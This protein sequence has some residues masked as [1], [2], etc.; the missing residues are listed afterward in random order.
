MRHL[1]YLV[2]LPLLLPLPYPQKIS[3]REGGVTLPKDYDEIGEYGL[4]FNTTPFD[5]P[6]AVEKVREIYDKRH[7][8]DAPLTLFA[9][10]MQDTFSQVVEDTY[11]DYDDAVKIFKEYPEMELV[12]ESSL[13]RFLQLERIRRRPTHE[14]IWNDSD[15]DEPTPVSEVSE[16]EGLS[17]GVAR[18]RTSGN[19]FPLGNNESQGYNGDSEERPDSEKVAQSRESSKSD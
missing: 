1:T 5:S 16:V 11:R 13:E 10:A 3:P 4:R 6:A 15:D 14:F 9:M 17:Q 7:K 19:L 12:M 8:G 2:I 18:I